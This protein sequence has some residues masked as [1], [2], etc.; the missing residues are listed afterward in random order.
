MD[1]D[2]NHTWS[3]IHHYLLYGGS[4]S[5]ILINYTLI[6]LYSAILYY[7]WSSNLLI[8]KPLTTLHILICTCLQVTVWFLADAYGVSLIWSGQLGLLFLILLI[9]CKTSKKT[10]AQIY[11]LA[12][13]CS[14]GLAA[15]IYY[16]VVYPPITTLAH[17][18]AGMVGFL[19][20]LLMLWGGG[21]KKGKEQHTVNSDESVL[22]QIRL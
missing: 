14:A 18:V 4:I 2:T 9:T 8:S 5:D 15:I 1:N 20:A 12:M 21:N 13:A 16:A 6:I 19:M 17:G 7:P 3:S 11:I 10:D 22:A